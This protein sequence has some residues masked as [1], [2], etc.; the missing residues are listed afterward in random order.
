MSVRFFFGVIRIKA[1]I[2]FVY[3]TRNIHITFMFVLDVGQFEK[4]RKATDSFVI[5]ACPSVYLSV[6]LHGTPRLHW[7]DVHQI[8]YWKISRKSC[9]K[10]KILLK[11][12]KSD[13]YLG[14]GLCTLTIMSVWIIL[15]TNVS[16]RVVWKVKT[17]IFLSIIFFLEKSYWTWNVCFIFFTSF[18][19][20]IS[21]SKK[22]RARYDHKYVGRSSCKVS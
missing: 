13:V 6:C 12:G 21:R 18:L 5:S 9:E 4:L 10:I 2:R 15:R 16:D 22:N 11:W 7:T 1:T 8:W 20:N 17:H 14:E 19:W 3:I